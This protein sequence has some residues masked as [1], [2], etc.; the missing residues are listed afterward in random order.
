MLAYLR[1]EIVR[2]FR[3]RRFTFFTL[4]VPVAFYLL[5]ANVFDD[6]GRDP[7]TGLDARTYLMVSMASF[8]A[9]GAALSSTG[10][11]FAAERASG[12]LRQ[13]RTT[14]LRPTAVVAART[15]AAMVLALPAILLVSLVAV[16]F[17]GVRVDPL[18]WLAMVALMWLGALPFAAL[19]ILIGSLV[20]PDAAQPVTLGCYFALSIMGGL[21]MPTD[22]LPSGLRAIAGWTPSNRF[23]SL[24]WTL[25][26]GHVPSATTG[27]VLAGWTAGL[28]G[29]AVP[30][31]RRTMRAS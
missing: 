9:I 1:L 30:A 25:V 10:Q 23:G 8:G 15:V 31:Y 6:G 27:L 26:S 21:W 3:D 5:W 7:A 18:H 29:L 16:A 13:L 4:A 20:G 14:P 12:W 19:G 2:M 17:Q 28:V 11:R 22:R 24:G